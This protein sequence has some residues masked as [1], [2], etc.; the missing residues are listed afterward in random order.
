MEHLRGWWMLTQLMSFNQFHTY[1]KYIWQR[2][3]YL[4]HHIKVVLYE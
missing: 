2:V 4:E 3:K 1:D